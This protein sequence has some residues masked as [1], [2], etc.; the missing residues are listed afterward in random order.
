MEGIAE[1]VM[2]KNKRY[3]FAMSPYVNVAVETGVWVCPW[4]QRCL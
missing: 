1:K 3:A 4:A 2:T